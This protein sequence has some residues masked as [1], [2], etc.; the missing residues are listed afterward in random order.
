MCPN[1][2]SEEIG[3]FLNKQKDLEKIYNKNKCHECDCVFITFDLDLMTDT[4]SV[5]NV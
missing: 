3:S 1:C 4:E 2:G 5:V